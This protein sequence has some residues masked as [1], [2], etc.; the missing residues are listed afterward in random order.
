LPHRILA[1]LLQQD[2]ERFIQMDEAFLHKNVEEF[3]LAREVQI[4]RSGGVS[5]AA[6]EGT[7]R[8]A[9]EPLAHEDFAGRP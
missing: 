7:H 5:D 8:K 2:A 1:S 4:D 9:F 3:F 6:R